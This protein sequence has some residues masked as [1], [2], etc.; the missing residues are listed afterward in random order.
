MQSLYR[1]QA[2]D[3]SVETDRFFFHR[4]QKMTAIDRWQMSDSMIRDARQMSL[5]NLK[6]RFSTLSP[7]AF[8]QKVAQAWLQ[9]DCPDYY[10]PL[11]TEMTWIQDSSSLAADLHRIFVALQ[12]PYYITGGVAA[13]VYGEPRT[14]RDL[15]IVLAIQREDLDPLVTALESNQF[16]VPGVDDVK[17]GR[18]RTLGITQIETIARADLVIAG[19]EEF[20]RIQF[21]RRESIEMPGLG[22]FYVVSP[23]DLILNKLRWGKRSQ[24]EKQWRDVLGILKV[25]GEMLDFEYLKRW[26]EPL[27]VRSDLDRLAAMA[28]LQ[29]P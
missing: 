29:I 27:D 26:A 23:E 11:G 5:W 18:M 21:D 12:I 24:S 3:T 4:L 8:A 14:T 19:Q 17:S 22:E 9:E 1:S 10:V 7:I 20:D 28:E 25:Q 2:E 16:Y 6:R 15:D 13:I